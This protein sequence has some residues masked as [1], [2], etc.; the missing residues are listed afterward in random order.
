M[1][2]SES[3]TG[4]RIMK[5]WLVIVRSEPDTDHIVPAVFRAAQNGQSIDLIDVSGRQSR[6]ISRR[7]AMFKEFENVRQQRK[8]VFKTR[9]SFGGKL[10]RIRHCR[11]VLRHWLQS[12]NVSLVVHE[13]WAGIAEE[14]SRLR[15]IRDFFFAD[16][17]IQLQRVAKALGIP[18]V[19][20]PH[21]HSLKVNSI[22][23][24]TALDIARENA[25]LLPFRNRESFAAYVVASEDDRD[26][27]CKS[28]DMNVRNVQVW[29]SPRFCAEW[30]EK[31]Y[32]ERLSDLRRAQ[33][34]PSN[35]LIVMCFLPKW[36]N[37]IERSPFLELLHGLAKEPLVE[38]WLREH[39]RKDET[40]LTAAEWSEFDALHNVRRRNLDEDTIDLI[41][42]CDVLLEIESSIA[43][44]AAILGKRVVMPRYLQDSSVVLK[45]DLVGGVTRT[46]DLVSTIQAIKDVRQSESLN[47]EFK[48]YVA[49]QI[50]DRTLDFY[51]ASLKNIAESYV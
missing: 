27:L 29:G 33:M 49:A 23:S 9:R 39:P 26:F 42:A 12:K 40:S 22:A 25:G 47:E 51:A 48:R 46:H 20:L 32:G 1:N 11:P 5:S 30:V 7:L 43:I 13:W 31:L 24:K 10:S 4:G 21:G 34:A 14:Q 45:Y 18:V 28:S 8:S 38:L 6:F 35:V 36:N 3:Q 37:S 41:A 17:P 16:F 15:Q 19:A 44:D 50:H 2:V